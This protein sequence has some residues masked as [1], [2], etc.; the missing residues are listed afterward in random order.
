MA[1]LEACSKIMERLKPYIDQNPEGAWRD[2]V[3][4]AYVDRVSL[5][6]TGFFKTPDIVRFNFETGEGR[7]FSYFSYGAAATEVEVD[8]LTGDHAVLR[9]D[10]V[11]DVGESL[12]PAIDIG[13]VEGAFMQG[14]RL[15][16][17]E[18]LCYSPE[19]VLLTRGPGMYKI[20]GF[21][22]IPREFNV[23][24]LR[25]A[26]NPRAVFSSKGVGESPLFLAASVFH[27]IKQALA[28]A[29]ADKGFDPVF[30]LDSPA[31]AERIRMAVPDF[32][33]RKIEPASPGTFKPWPASLPSVKI[34]RSY[35]SA[36]CDTDHSLVCSSIMIRTKKIHHT[37]KKGRPLI[38]STK[39]RNQDKVEYFGR[40]LEEALPGSAGVTA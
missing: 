23:S 30:R 21:Q 19:G 38:D 22:D 16:T 37:K 17:L 31:T 2:W 35:Q 10:I 26:P 29:R 20:P 40:V 14:M 6:A 4:A 5:F 1:V 3:N 18:E 39:T 24:L 28:A 13:Q 12:N 7:P 36:V 11:M 15:F 27:G 25:G 34:M 8:C 9:T 33:T 32:L